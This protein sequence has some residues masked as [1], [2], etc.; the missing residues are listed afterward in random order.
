MMKSGIIDPAKASCSTLQNAASIVPLLLITECAITN[1]PEKKNLHLIPGGGMG[2]KGRN[3][4]LIKTSSGFTL[5]RLPEN[6]SLFSCR[7]HVFRKKPEDNV[8]RRLSD[9][10]YAIVVMPQSSESPLPR[11]IDK[12]RIDRIVIDVHEHPQKICCSR[13]NSGKKPL[14]P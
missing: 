7:L 12:L 3:I 9:T 2:G 1:L 14:A 4:L 8:I 11:T 6:C 10:F 5:A 13:N